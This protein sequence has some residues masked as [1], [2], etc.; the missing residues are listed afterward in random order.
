MS[1]DRVRE[2]MRQNRKQLRMTLAPPAPPALSPEAR[3]GLSLT[4]GTRVFDTVSGQ[5]GEVLGGTRENVVVH[6]PERAAD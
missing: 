3:I 5:D 4:P 2:L 1:V 6:H